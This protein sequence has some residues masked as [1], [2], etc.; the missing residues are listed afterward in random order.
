M[1]RYMRTACRHKRGAIS[2]FLTMLIMLVGGTATLAAVI[3]DSLLPLLTQRAEIASTLARPIARCVQRRD[4]DH[5]VFHGCVDWHSSVHAT[6][7]LVAFTRATGDP[8]YRPLIHDLLDPELLRKERANLKSYE[9]FEMRTAGLG[10][11]AWLSITGAPF[12]AICWTNS[13]MKSP[14][15]CA[16]ITLH[17]NLYRFLAH[18]TTM[19]G[20]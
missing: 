18:I 3:P 7:S 4:T 6:W 11:C 17:T 9:G 14:T 2:A 8:R 16:A 15:L 19:L 12:K 13:P 10:F 20:R 5:P 1:W